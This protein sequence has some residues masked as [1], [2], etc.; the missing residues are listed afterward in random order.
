MQ[1]EFCTILDLN[2]L[3]RGLVLYRSL[4][5][6]CEEFR[7]SVFCMDFE[8]R[9]ILER[10]RLPRL[11]TIGID[12]LEA[13]DPGL[14]AVR[15]TRNAVE[16][17]WTAKPSACLYAIERKPNVDVVAF[18][19]ADTMFFRDPKPLFDELGDSFVAVTPARDPNSRGLA[20]YVTM[21]MPFRCDERAQMALRWWRERCL[22]WCYDEVDEARLGDL[23]YL[24]EW[25]RR[26]RGVRVLAHP[27]CL[28]EWNIK[29]FDLAQQNGD[30]IVDGH[31]LILF[32]Y[33]ALWLYR[34]FLTR[35]PRL[36]FLASYY[37]VTPPP[38]VWATAF[39]I[40]INQR[41]LL[42]DPYVQRL[43]QAVSDLRALDPAFNAGLVRLSLRELAYS[44]ARRALPRAIRT[45]LK[46]FLAPRRAIRGLGPPGS[47]LK[48]Q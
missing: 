10:M 43:G 8:T 16:Y 47:G 9:S 15:R 39:A 12:E 2:Y 44:T 14:R 21:F 37:H 33:G 41:R 3:L 32:H 1:K 4:E 36:G 7:L 38:L 46:R 35:L 23:T 19:E 34:G 5:S 24:S 11:V 26:F 30:V 20:P 42:W 6:V 45:P 13:Y 22:E 40:P 18:V 28:G 25:P 29:H 27:G 48:Q 17:C 31:P